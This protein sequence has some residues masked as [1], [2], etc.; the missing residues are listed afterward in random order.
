MWLR[1]SGWWWLSVEVV[2]LKVV[3]GCCLVFIFFG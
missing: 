2:W 1:L 3:I